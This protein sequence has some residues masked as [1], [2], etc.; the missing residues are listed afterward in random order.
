VFV[1]EEGL[2][3]VR[4]FIGD[5]EAPQLVPYAWPVTSSPAVQVASQE[6][7]TFLHQFQQE[8]PN[9]PVGVTASWPLYMD[10]LDGDNDLVV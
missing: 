1:H 9:L 8:N 6:M 2:N 7:E 10:Q 4:G 3:N 5:A